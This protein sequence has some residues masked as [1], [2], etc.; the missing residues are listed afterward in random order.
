MS[1]MILAG[2]YNEGLTFTNFIILVKENFFLA[3]FPILVALVME[4]NYYLQLTQTNLKIGSQTIISRSQTISIFDITSIER[5]PSKIFKTWGSDIV[6][7]ISTKEGDTAIAVMESNFTISD[8]KDFLQTLK[9]LHPSLELTQ[10]YQ[11]LLAGKYT[12]GHF[13]ELIA[14]D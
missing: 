8:I 13:R 7:N 3:I 11:D 14:E 5:K 1:I 2:T 6:M 12:D 9:Q 4:L 10:Q